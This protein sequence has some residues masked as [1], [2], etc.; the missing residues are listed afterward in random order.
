LPSGA[1]ADFGIV[2]DDA[3]KA[4]GGA[5]QSRLHYD[6]N[7]R[8]GYTDF[9]FDPHSTNA[10]YWVEVDNPISG[11]RERHEFRS[12]R[13][14]E[15][16]FEEIVGPRPEPEARGERGGP[17][18]AR[19][20]IAP[21]PPPEGAG[22]LAAAKSQDE[23]VLY[24][25]TTRAG[26]EQ[27]EREGIS[28]EGRVHDNQDLGPAFYLTE[29]RATGEHYAT[30]RQRQVDADAN[31]PPGQGSPGEVMEFRIPREALGVIVDVREGGEHRAL[32]EE[33]LSRPP[34]ET[35]FSASD[36][37]RYP[38]LAEMMD[39]QFPTTQECLESPVGVARGVGFEHFLERYNLAHADFVIG[40]LGGKL[41]LGGIYLSP[42]EQFAARSPKAIAA[43]NEVMRARL[44]LDPEPGGS[45]VPRLGPKREPETTGTGPRPVGSTRIDEATTHTGELAHETGDNEKPLTAGFADHVDPVAGFNDA[46]RRSVEL[47]KELERL[48]GIEQNRN[49]QVR[50]FRTALEEVLSVP[51][52]RLHPWM[53]ELDL[54]IPADIERLRPWIDEHATFKGEPSRM[55]KAFDAY[56]AVLERVEG[57]EARLGAAQARVKQDQAA[58]H[59][60]LARLRV[61]L[62]TEAKLYNGVHISP[63]L[64][65]P[66]AGWDYEPPRLVGGTEANQLSHLHGFQ[67]ELRLA[68]DIVVNRGEEVVSYGIMSGVHGADVVSVH[69]DTGEVTLWDSKY[70][71]D[72]SVHDGSSTFE[73]DNLEK[74]R[75]RALADLKN[76]ARSGHLPAA[77]RAQAIDNLT[78]GNFHTATVSSVEP[79]ATNLYP[80]AGE[81]WQTIRD[82]KPVQ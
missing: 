53:Q 2:H 41:Q 14:Y 46:T 70:L 22:P 78:R 73:G 17:A 50:A 44:G 37:A 20:D 26:R 82:H 79:T 6:D 40:D 80:V 51:A 71:G 58:V 67:A 39:L 54:A 10:R 12:I 49:D 38:G 35:V 18:I 45:G 64:G 27:I 9:G 76:D 75:L 43:L 66:V 19:R 8:L 30:T 7:G 32:W 33:F 48:N 55:K 65:A 11:A 77:A 3:L 15:S 29:D 16:F 81:K 25:G 28:L 47:G 31:I 23:L 52:S 34:S 24:H 13:D 5:H 74:A 61:R 21:P 1:E 59:A 4:G 72:G 63:Q 42:R 69:P 56:L 60:D 68:N 57:G 62:D 36:K